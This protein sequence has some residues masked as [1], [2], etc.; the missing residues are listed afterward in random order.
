[1]GLWDDAAADAVDADVL[2]EQADDAGRIQ[3]AEPVD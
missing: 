2:G 1:M 3:E